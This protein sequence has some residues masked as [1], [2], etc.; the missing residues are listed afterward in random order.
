M[1]PRPVVVSFFRSI[2]NLL[3]KAVTGERGREIV[4]APFG[5]G[6]STPMHD[7]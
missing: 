6:V 4:F 2:R 5:E 7:G 3:P 1:R